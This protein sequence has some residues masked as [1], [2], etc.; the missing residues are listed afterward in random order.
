MPM[1]N[2]SS[3]ELLLLVVVVL[4]SRSRRRSVEGI[5][6]EGGNTDTWEL[7]QFPAAVA[8][9]PPFA[10]LYK[11]ARLG[12]EGQED[13]DEEDDDAFEELLDKKLSCVCDWGKQQE[14]LPSSLS[15]HPKEVFS[16]LIIRAGA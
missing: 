16:T 14:V 10:K 13:D 5:R 3:F 2:S 4:Q 12:K 9:A 15:L 8:A 7:L 6:T 11:L 1:K